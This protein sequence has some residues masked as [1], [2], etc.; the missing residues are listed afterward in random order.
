LFP[1]SSQFAYQ[2]AMS[3]SLPDVALYCDLQFSSDGMGFCKTGLTL[4]NS[5]LIAEVFP[6]MEKTY[7]VNGEDV[8]GWFS[9]DFTADQ[10]VQN[11]TCKQQKRSLTT[12]SWDNYITS[13]VKQWS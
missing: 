5:T 10:L 3:A 9:L 7:K 13:S 8:R 6:K 2:F 12:F 1:D 4:D 11:V